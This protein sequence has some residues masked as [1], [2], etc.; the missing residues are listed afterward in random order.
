MWGSGHRPLLAR[1]AG[2][3]RDDCPVAVHAFELRDGRGWRSILTPAVERGDRLR[4]PEVR[5]GYETRLFARLAMPLPQA[6]RSAAGRYALPAAVWS[7]MGEA[8]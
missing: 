7:A 4:A 2:P 1:R 8:T 5:L 3:N 6:A